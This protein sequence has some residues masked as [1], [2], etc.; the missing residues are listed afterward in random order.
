MAERSSL[1]GSRL[2]ATSYEDERHVE[3]AERQ[4]VSYDCSAGHRFEVPFSTEAEVPALWECPRCGAQA[5]RLQTD[6]PEEKA[7][8]PART[9][10]DMLLERRSIEDLEVLLDER[11]ELLRSGRLASRSRLAQAPTARSSSRRK[12]A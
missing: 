3:L 10:W 7:G 11:L 12:S 8:K 1:R 4:V 9:H 6:R 2:G 5:L